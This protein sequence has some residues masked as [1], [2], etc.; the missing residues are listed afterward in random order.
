MF[1]PLG[2]LDNSFGDNMLLRLFFLFEEYRRSLPRSEFKVFVSDEYKNLKAGEETYPRGYMVAMATRIYEELVGGSDFDKV[3]EDIKHT[4]L[5]FTTLPHI[6]KK[7]TQKNS[8]IV[9]WI[10][11]K[12]KVK[13]FFK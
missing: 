7:S 9:F 2:W 12:R 1:M 3:L 13:S 11:L 6:E 5:Q 10:G 4:R 8:D